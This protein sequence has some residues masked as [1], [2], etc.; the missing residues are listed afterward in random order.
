MSHV[1]LTIT[2]KGFS[3]VITSANPTVIPRRGDKVDM[4]YLPVSTVIEVLWQ[5]TAAQT[6]VTVVVN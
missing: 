4:G 1:A 3:K 5:Y 6:T 2:D